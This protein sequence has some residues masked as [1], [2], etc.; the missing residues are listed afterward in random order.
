[1]VTGLGVYI[2]EFNEDGSLK[3]DVTE[4]ALSHAP[5]KGI[6]SIRYRIAS[7]RYFY[8]ILT[9]MI[10]QFT[11]EKRAELEAAVMPPKAA[12]ANKEVKSEVVNNG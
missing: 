4:C 12:K 9:D 5:V 6:H 3:T 7:T 10:H 1:M 2:G 8:R 11:D